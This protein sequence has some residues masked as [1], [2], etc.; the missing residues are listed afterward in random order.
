[1][2]EPSPN[3]AQNGWKYPSKCQNPSPIIV[4]NIP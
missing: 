3:Y 4:E 2:S 1:V